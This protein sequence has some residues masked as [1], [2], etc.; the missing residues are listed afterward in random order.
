MRTHELIGPEH[1]ITSFFVSELLM[2]TGAEIPLHT[3]P[4]EEAFLVA[5]GALTVHL[6]EEHFVAQAES[7]FRIPPGVPHALRN[8][9]AQTARALAAAAWN[10]ATWFS[11][12]TT[13]LE[14]QAR[15]T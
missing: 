14:G 6:G 11:Q 8:E 15:S 2:Q 12:G 4:N 1:G 5:E 10:R 9:G 13:Y 3:H 7:V